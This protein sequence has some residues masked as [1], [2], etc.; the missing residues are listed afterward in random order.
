M[1]DNA[2]MTPTFSSRMG[3]AFSN[4]LRAF[5]IL[6]IVAGI[7]A[8]V[9]FGTPW[10]YQK[11]ILPIETNTA[12][13]ED[14]EGKQTDEVKKINSQMNDLKARMSDLE[15]SQT[16]NSSSIAELKGQMDALEL[17]VDRQSEAIKQLDNIQTRLDTLQKSN[18]NH[19]GLLEELDRQVTI[20]RSIELLSRAYIYLVQN[21]YGLARDDLRAAYTLLSELEVE[22][23]QALQSVL[24]RLEMAIANL[25]D[26]P[27]VAVDD[28]EAAWQLLI[29]GFSPI[30]PANLI[31][32][33]PTIG[34]T[35]EPTLPQDNAPEVT[36]EN[37]P[38]LTQTPTP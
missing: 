25:P 4:L 15:N 32:P 20:T 28:V 29:G 11:I 7:A 26:Y 10:L 14:V 22:N 27:I 37:N 12:R 24:K 13:L 5:L 17:I 31:I 6:V 2:D 35:P 16:S 38:A 9:Y 30:T 18:E 33:T 3:K 19:E 8:A 23:A 21:N 1:N 34:T 36:P